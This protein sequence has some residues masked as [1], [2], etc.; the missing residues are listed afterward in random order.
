MAS[1]IFSLRVTSPLAF[2]FFDIVTGY[3][4][5]IP[6]KVFFD[7]DQFSNKVYYEQKC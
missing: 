1:F 3:N 4:K 7:I 6:Y 2:D 5:D